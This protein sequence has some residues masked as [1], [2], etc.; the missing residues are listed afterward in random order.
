MRE[1]GKAPVVIHVQ[2]REDDRLYI[3]RT[4]PQGAQLRP[5]FLVTVDAECHLP[6]DIRVKRLSGVEQMRS[7]TSVDHDD[8][9]LVFDNPGVRW[10]PIC[11]RSI[12]ENGESS[13]QTVSPPFD[14]RR[15]DPDSARLDG[16]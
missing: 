6:S 8:T 15:L 16:M 7:L 14:L 13:S 11:P 3:A 12:A 2:M 10:Q 4:D 1:M 9:F 5:D